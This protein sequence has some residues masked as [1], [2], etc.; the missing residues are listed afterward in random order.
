MTWLRIT[1][2]PFIAGWEKDKATFEAARFL[3][4]RRTS[5][6]PYRGFC[7]ENGGN[8][9]VVWHAHDLTDDPAEASDK[10]DYTYISGG[11]E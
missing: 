8:E 4:T 9:S 10:I 7:T 1:T 5:Y 3:R 6:E 11:G 2:W